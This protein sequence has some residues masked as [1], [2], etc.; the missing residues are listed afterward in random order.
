MKNIVLT[1]LLCGMC[2]ATSIRTEALKEEKEF[3]NERERLI[4]ESLKIGTRVAKELDK[5][6]FND[7]SI[8]AL[9]LVHDFKI[10]IKQL[11][12]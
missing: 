10:N 6:F 12:T 11:D 8:L 3:N 4:K 7:L 2:F 5:D 9:Q 1:F